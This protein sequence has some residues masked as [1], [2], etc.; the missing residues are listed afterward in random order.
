M[1]P[2]VEGGVLLG[3]EAPAVP[4]L[5]GPLEVLGLD[6]EGPH[7]AAVGQA[8]PA[9]AGDVVADLP[10]GP[11]RVLER[12]VPQH[13]GRVLQHGQK[14]AGRADLQ[15]RG[16]LAHVGVADDHV[17]PPEPLG[18]GVRL[19]AG[20]DDGAAPGGGRRHPLPDVLGPLAEAEDRA[21]GGLE[22]LAG[23]GV[24]LPADEERD[25]HLGVAVEVVVALGQV[26]LVAA[27]GVAGRVGVVLEQV[28]VAADA[29]LAQAGLGAGDQPAE[30]P[31]PRLVVGHDVGDL[32][33]LGRGVL[34]VAAHI[35]VEA[36]PVLEEHVRGAPPADH[37]AEEV[38]GH[39]VGAEPA[40]A[41]QGEGHPV[42]VLDAEDALLHEATVQPTRPEEAPARRRRCAGRSAGRR[43]GRCPGS[44]WPPR[45]LPAPASGRARPGRR[46]P[47]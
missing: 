23:P 16:V 38:A 22:D 42:L 10:D 43:S 44:A 45:G 17:E 33:A 9:L 35:E 41:A 4:E 46:R 11:D 27:V 3:R 31:L 8:D 1:L 12:Q 7:L 20:V 36:G 28:D 47:P 24:D 30:D 26:V 2:H 34:G 6:V 21:P 40:L 14:D 5:E 18:V 39:L 15:E 32:V 13:G 25:Q 19:V 29:L 37:P